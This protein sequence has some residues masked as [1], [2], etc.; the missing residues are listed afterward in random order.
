MEVTLANDNHATGGL[1]HDAR[2]G[3]NHVAGQAAD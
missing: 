2:A 3:A 1:T